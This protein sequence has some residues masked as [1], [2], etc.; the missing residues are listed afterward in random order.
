MSLNNNLKTYNTALDS[1]VSGASRSYMAFSEGKGW[2]GG[3]APM[4]YNI[5]HL[6]V[7]IYTGV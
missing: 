6:P 1:T 4:A 2:Y 3:T 5:A 7:P